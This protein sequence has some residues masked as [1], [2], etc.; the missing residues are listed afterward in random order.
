MFV[1]LCQAGSLFDGFLDR[2]FVQ[3]MTTRVPISFG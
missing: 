2:C 1:N 3:V